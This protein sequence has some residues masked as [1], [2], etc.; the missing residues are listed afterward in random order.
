MTKYCIRLSDS[1]S[2]VLTSFRLT[3]RNGTFEL[4]TGFGSLHY[5]ADPLLLP[6]QDT[7]CALIA[8]IRAFKPDGE[9][10]IFSAVE[11][12]QKSELDA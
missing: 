3:P 9:A 7:A 4:V 10:L 6:S 2:F 1:P 12:L 5:D 8:L 11:I